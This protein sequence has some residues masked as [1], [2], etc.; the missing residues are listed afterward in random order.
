MIRS[1]GQSLCYDEQ[2]REINCVGSGQDAA[3]GLGAI[4]PKPRFDLQGEVVLDRLTGLLWTRDANLAE[5]PLMWS[6]ALKYV[7]DMNVKHAFGHA[8]WRLP[9][10]REL[11]SL[12]DYQAKKPALSPEHPFENVVLSWYWTSTSA[13]INPGYAWYVHLEGA[14]TFYGRKDQYY[15]TWPV[16]GKDASRLWRTGQTVCFDSQ[17]GR[18]P[19]SGTGQDGDIRFGTPWPEPRFAL[20]AGLVHD[21]LTRLTWYARADLT[22]GSV[23]WGTALDN[24]RML[25][26][27]GHHQGLNWRLPNILELES[28]VDCST[29]NP[30]LPAG[31]Q[32]SAVQ[33]AYWSSTT[34]FFETNW[35]WVLYLHKGALGVGFK[36]K[37]EFAVWPVAGPFPY[38]T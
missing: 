23:S 17:G 29:H 11:L 25:K 4:W 12:I 27:Q 34:S 19:C 36:P 18:I 32:F 30:A 14:R 9:N 28:L 6:E 5:I 15:L 3:I 31:H 38:H 33:E 2:G 8:D 22:G 1:T 35:A 16:R 10:R 37:P 24:I 21:R 26:D 13:A 7:A 20:R